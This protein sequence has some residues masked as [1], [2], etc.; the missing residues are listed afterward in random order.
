[1][2]WVKHKCG[3]KKKVRMNRIFLN[4]QRYCKL[5][6]V[7]PPSLV[8]VSNAIRV[9]FLCLSVTAVKEKKS[10]RQFPQPLLAVKFVA[11]QVMALP[12]SASMIGLE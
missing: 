4:C 2:I 3:K 11:V 5:M 1:M 9:K 7:C 10:L 6:S 12:G 8:L